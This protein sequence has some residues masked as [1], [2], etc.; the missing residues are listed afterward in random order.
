MICDIS[1]WRLGDR[2]EDF[3]ISAVLGA[4]NAQFAPEAREKGLRLKVLPNNTRVH[5]DPVLL[6]RVLSN[7]VSNAVRYTERGGVL[8]GCRRRGANLQ[9]AV[10][11]TGCG[12]S[13]DHRED[14]FPRVR[15]ARQPGP[16]SR[17]GLGRDSLCARL[18]PLL[19]GRV[20]LNRCRPGLDVRD[21]R[22]TC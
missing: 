21:Q 9:I 13:E 5:S 17:Q 10:W 4:I 22:S 15:A 19:G 20:D 12:I 7:F 18:A 2:P 16:G 3:A 11:D 14:I 8:V 1:G 6:Q